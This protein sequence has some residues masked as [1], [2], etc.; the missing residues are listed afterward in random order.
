MKQK[1]ILSSIWR[2]VTVAAAA[3]AIASVTTSGC[4][5]GNDDDASLTP[6]DDDDAGVCPTGQT[7]CKGVCVDTK[8]DRAN[9]GTC[10]KSCSPG[11]VCSDGQCQLSCQVGLVECEGTCVSTSQDRE[12]CGE[13]GNACAQGE[14][15]SGGHCLLFCQEG[16]T[17]CEGSCVD[18][19]T[20]RR[21]CGACGE[22]CAAGEV[23]D[24][25]ECAL[26]CQVGLTECAGTCVDTD[27]S[28]QHCGS[29]GKS[30]ASGEVCSNGECR[31][32][33]QDKLTEC[34]GGC[35]NTQT[36]R[37][38]CGSCDEACDPG[39]VC[40]GGSCILSCQEGLS[41]CGGTCV[42][43]KTD[44]SNCGICGKVCVQGEVCS[45][46]G[47]ALSCQPTFTNCDGACVNLKTDR[48]YCGTC[49]KACSSTQVCNGGVCACQPGQTSCG[50]ACVDLS[51]NSNHCG[52][53]GKA[54]GVNEVCSAGGCVAIVDGNGEIGKEGKPKVAILGAVTA[55]GLADG[56]KDV[57]TKLAALN[58]FDTVDVV[59][60][61]DA[62][63]A[64]EQLEAYD[65]VAYLAYWPAAN[66]TLM[67]DVLA[68]YLESG[69]GV[70]VFSYA[71]WDAQGLND[72]KGRYASQYALMSNTT[73]QSRAISA[74]ST[75]SERVEPDSPLLDGVTSFSCTTSNCYHLR[76]ALKN[77]AIVVA[78]WGHGHPLVLRRD[79]DGHKVVELNVKG[80]SSDTNAGA[81]DPATDGAT[82][83]KNALVYTIP[84]MVTASARLDL[85]NVP[86]L[87]A[88]PAQT[89]VYKNTSSSPQTISSIERSGAHIG[90]FAVTPANSVPVTLAPGETLDV[91]VV[92]TPTG[93]GLRAATVSVT[94]DG[95]A[96]KLTTLLVGK[97]V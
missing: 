17:D 11:N 57:Q 10:G 72:L 84:K 20:D 97:G 46:G 49:D 62:T 75:L 48:G 66:P 53:C 26:S 60:V 95:F 24:G 41:S 18:I 92:F 6:R 1:P 42:N 51:T 47:C 34:G 3:V 30:C 81:W 43:T 52:A 14:V 22:V 74:S 78:K 76:T 68:D 63:P 28:R 21:H 93:S 44:R 82:L 38:H 31:V 59:Y 90:D 50:D 40:S 27:T 64:L 33:C 37:K 61:R 79:F 88:A 8:K 65:A 29:C 87:T 91:G 35:V 5:A 96:T 55:G 94:V 7:S 67:G 56:A 12:H 77:E 70:V 2:M 25:G 9:C 58:A 73:S 23:C 69:G 86:V 54:C 89:I 36:D 85:G 4:A 32:S 39:E 19:D 16:L 45:D 15:C 83:I 71:A 13:C 80:G